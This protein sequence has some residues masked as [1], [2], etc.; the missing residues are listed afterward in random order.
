LVVLPDRIRDLAE[1]AGPR[2]NRLV[3][4]NRRFGLLAL[5]QE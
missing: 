4:W 5:L 3:R 1:A 2:C